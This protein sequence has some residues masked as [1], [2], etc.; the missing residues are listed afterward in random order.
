MGNSTPDEGLWDLK[1]KTHSQMFHPQICTSS[2]PVTLYI[3]FIYTRSQSVSF[4]KSLCG[5]IYFSF[6]FCYPYW[7]ICTYRVSCDKIT[8]WFLFICGTSL[9]LKSRFCFV[10]IVGSIACVG[11]WR[12]D[13]FWGFRCLLVFTESLLCQ[14]YWF[15]L[16]TED[17][18]VKTFRLLKN[19]EVRK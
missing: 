5:R 19:I 8:L 17:R 13:L 1:K 15:L 7:H 14:G 18:W 4:M 10:F 9:L 16:D 2:P 3:H 12:A 6:W 11:A